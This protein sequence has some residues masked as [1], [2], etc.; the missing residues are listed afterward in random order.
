MQKQAPDTN[1]TETRDKRNG[2]FRSHLLAINIPADG[3]LGGMNF[4]QSSEGALCHSGNE[5]GLQPTP[6]G[7][8]DE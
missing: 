8:Y 5:E 1:G 6:H 3:I 4:S 2:Q 7:G